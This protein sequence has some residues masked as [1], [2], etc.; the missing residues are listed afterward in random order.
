MLISES[1][2]GFGIDLSWP[3]RDPKCSR[4]VGQAAV[5]NV[6]NSTSHGPPV[7]GEIWGMEECGEKHER[8]APSAPREILR[9][10]QSGSAMCRGTR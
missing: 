4:G 8:N 2:P 5:R 7:Q 10:E 9:P 3:Q 6:G 1:G